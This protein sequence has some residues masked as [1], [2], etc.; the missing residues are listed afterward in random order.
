MPVRAIQARVQCTPDLLQV[1]WQTHLAFNKRLPKLL[2]ILFKMRRC[3]CGDTEEK[4]KLYAVIAEFAIA[5][6]ARDGPYL[7]N[8][9]SIPAWK[10][11][12][13][14]SM[15]IELTGEDGR[16]RVVSGEEWADEAAKLSA[17][18]KLLY[19]KHALLG[20]L[21]ETLKQM[22]AR[23]CIAII[24]GHQELLK[25]WESEHDCWLRSKQKWESD[26]E[27]QAYLA[28]RPQF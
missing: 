19:D 15:K 27:H 11:N 14:K 24:S 5:R 17:A 4:R 16:L 12:T 10:P 13:A 9:V 8:S 2:S 3:E 21:P 28:V 25:R 1:L 18:G 7:L 23:E 26:S 22:V 6:P 20:G